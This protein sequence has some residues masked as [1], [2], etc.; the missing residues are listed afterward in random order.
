LRK[1]GNLSTFLFAR[2]IFVH[3]NR[4]THAAAVVLEKMMFC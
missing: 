3:E 1:V 2:D 4:C